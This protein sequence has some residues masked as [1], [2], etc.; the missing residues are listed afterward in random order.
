MKIARCAGESSAFWALVDTEQGEARPIAGALADWAPQVTD[1]DTGALHFD[2]PAVA[3]ASVRLLPP[4]ESTA[5]VIAAG[6]TYAKHIA[7]LGLK[8]PSRP[9]A[10]YKGEWSLVGPTDD[11][12]Y[13]AITEA[14]DYEVELV[15]IVG[16]DVTDPADAHRCILGY[17][18]GNDV[19]A[20]DW[21]FSESVTGMDMFSAKTLEHTSPIGPWIVT[22]D[23][24]GDGH[25]DLE[26][27]LTVDGERRQH[28]RTTSMA[29]PVGEILAWVHDRVPQRCG[30]V[31]FTGTPAGVAHEDGRYLEPGQEVVARV[32]RIGELRNVI[33]KRP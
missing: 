15:V 21:Q 20:R 10:F 2:G 17:T 30:D 7:G 14:L 16:K 4:V 5:R 8:M 27:E 1:G 19:T 22:R 33:G 25:P 26:L 23:E 24:F 31:L 3:L 9:A 28:D 18:A 12:S 13:P 6:A 29:W 32:E 11:I